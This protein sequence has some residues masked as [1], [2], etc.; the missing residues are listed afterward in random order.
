MARIVFDLDGTLVHS[1]PTL[2]AAGNT[3]LAEMG[4]D[5]L[6]VERVVG[7]VGHGARHLVTELLRAT[8]GVP[9][10]GTDAA[11][12]RFHAIYDA[13]PVS[14]SEPY[15]AVPDALAALA[16]AGH[17]LAVCTQKAVAPSRA[18]LRALGLMPPVTGLTGGDSLDVLKPD[19]RMLRHAA[20]QLPSGPVVLVGDSEIDAATAHAAGVP[21]LLH[22]CGYAHVPH[23]AL[24][25]R[26]VF[27]D[28]ATLPGLVAEILRAEVAS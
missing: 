5:T 9:D 18:I 4:R 25:A 14:G 6:P 20:D 21:F 15:P 11:L 1:A 24:G 12:S 13:D 17:G 10:E 8:G 28:F 26:G 27:N 7:H 22:L 19:P 3:L 23:E 2:A 16:A